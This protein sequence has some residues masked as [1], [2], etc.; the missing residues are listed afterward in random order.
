MAKL[1]NLSI[2]GIDV[3]DFIIEG[4]GSLEVGLIE[5]GIVEY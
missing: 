3:T 2:N 5:N 1:K 4:G